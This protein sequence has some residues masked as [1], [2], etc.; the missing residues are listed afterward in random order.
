MKLINVILIFAIC[1]MSLSGCNNPDDEV[2]IEAT[3]ID[4]A[5]RNGQKIAL[6]DC[7]DPQQ[8][9]AV[10]VHATTGNFGTLRSKEFDVV[11]NGILY[12]LTFKG[13]ATMLIPIDLKEGENVASI[14][15][16]NLEARI[17]KSLPNEFE[18]VE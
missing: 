5:Y 13:E 16:T 15:G 14:A 10:L 4:F 17:S 3:G 9:F 12:N 1:I 6:G 7:I 2:I 8:N 11:V 18:L